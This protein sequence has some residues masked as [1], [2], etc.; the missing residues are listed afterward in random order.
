MLAD[1]PE[2][3]LYAVIAADRA[4]AVT[5]SIASLVRQRWGAAPRRQERLQQLRR[6][7][8]EVPEMA[9]GR[10][11]VAG[12]GQVIQIARPPDGGG[13]R[14]PCARLR[15]T[16][17]TPARRCGSS[18]CPPSAVRGA[19]G[20]GAGGAPVARPGRDQRAQPPRRLRRLPGRARPRDGSRPLGQEHHAAGG[21]RGLPGRSP[22]LTVVAVAG[23]L[24]LAGDALVDEVVRPGEIGDRLA[25]WST[26][27]PGGC[28]YSST[29]PRPSTTSAAS[30]TASRRPTAP[31]CC[32]WPRDA[33]TASAPATRTGPR[34]LRRSKLGVLLRPDIDLDGD[35]LGVTLPRR[36]PVAMVPGRGY[37]A[38]GGEADLVQVALPR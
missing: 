6:R 1:G 33:T 26:P 13:G 9:P 31:T 14:R 20:G 28:W 10:A 12:T 38:A 21:G 19:G 7:S 35:I 24:A 25:C 2:V 18:R 32:S 11:L 16:P 36:A 29:T 17:P 30:S 8:K 27:P 3:G 34:P 15:S 37:V 5:S 4:M 23:P 22:E